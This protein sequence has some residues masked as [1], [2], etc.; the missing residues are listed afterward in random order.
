MALR[1]KSFKQDIQRTKN[2]HTL[3]D[4]ACTKSFLTKEMLCVIYTA[5]AIVLTCVI[6]QMKAIKGSENSIFICL[7]W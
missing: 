4:N 1:L 2:F 6:V 3:N 5:E 7:V